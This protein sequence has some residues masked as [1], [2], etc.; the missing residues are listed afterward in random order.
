VKTRFTP[1]LLILI[2]VIAAILSRFIGSSDYL[3]AQS[4]SVYGYAYKFFYCPYNKL[5]FTSPNYPYRD[6]Y[7][8]YPTM[9]FPSPYKVYY[10][11]YPPPY[12]YPPVPFPGPPCPCTSPAINPLLLDGEYEQ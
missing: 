4:S 5:P 8:G 3:F 2:I 1:I 10:Y 9:R 11:T 12:Q 6:L 7:R